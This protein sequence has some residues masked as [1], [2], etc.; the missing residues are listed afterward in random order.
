MSEKSRVPPRKQQVGISVGSEP[1]LSKNP[2]LANLGGPDQGPSAAT[3][4]QLRQELDKAVKASRALARNCARAEQEL[5]RREET[6]ALIAQHGSD[7]VFRLSREGKFLELSPTC[8]ALLG[9][10]P[11]TFQGRS[12]QELVPLEELEPLRHYFQSVLHGPVAAGMVIHLLN[13]DGPARELELHCRAVPHPQTQVLEIV[14]IARMQPPRQAAAAPADDLASSLAHELNQPLTALAIA[15]RACSELARGRDVDM[16]EMVLAIDQLAVQAERAGELVRRMRQLAARVTPRWTSVSLEDLTHDAVRMLK[17]DLLR[18]QVSIRLHIPGELPKISIDRIQIEQVLVNLI[19]N[20]L[21]A[22]C[23]M[24]VDQ[25]VLTIGASVQDAEVVMSI[26][27][28]GRG[29][30]PAIAERLFQ[31]YQTTKPQGMGLG[32]AVSRAILQAHAGR[33]WVAPAHGPGTTFCL[34]LPLAT[35]ES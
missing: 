18:D 17:S 15:A 26:A 16:Q 32:L 22:M 19:R 21:E 4:E 1:L 7:L 35:R 25:R 14:G 6:F 9:A 33:L 2:V 5:R 10:D 34:A 31:P 29:L 8:H 24:P 28:T 3:E 30:S 13:R 27:D 12:L 23:E 11:A 20:A